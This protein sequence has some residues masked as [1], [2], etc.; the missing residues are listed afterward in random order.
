[1][2]Q[3]TIAVQYKTLPT[4]PGVYQYFDK[5]DT[6][7][8]VGKAKNLKRRVTSYFTKVHDN[9]KTRILVKKIHRMEHIVVPTEVDALLL[10]NNLIKKYRP[11]YNILLKD[12]KT[13]PWICIK[14]EAFP[15]VFSTR[16]VIRDGSD[17]FGPYPNVKTVYTLLELIRGLYPI[18]TCNFDLSEEKIKKQSYKVCLE[19]H[20]GNCLAPCESMVS[21]DDYN[22]NIAAIRE[23]IKGNFRCSLNQF[24]IQMEQ[25]ANAMEFERAQEIKEK[26][27]SLEN[28]Q[29]KSTV[30]NSKIT[31]V[32]VFTIISDESYGYVNFFQVAFG[33]IIRSHTVE[34]KKKLEETEAEMLPL[35][36]VNLRQRFNSQSKEILVPF[37]VDLGPK[38]KVTIPKLGDKKKLVELSQRN[39]KFFRLERFKQIKIVD[40]ERHIKRLMNQMK[41]DLRLQAEPIHIEC[42]DNSNIQGTNPTAACVVFRNGKPFKKD[43]R[44]FKIKTVEGP[45]D[46][47][48]MEEVVHRRYKRLSDEG[49]SLPQLIVIDG[50]KGQLSSAVKSLDRLGLRGQIAIIGIAKRLEEIYYPGDG[51]PMYLDKKSETLKVIQQLRNEAHRFGLTLHRNIRSKN[52]LKS[53]L[54]QVEG[55]GP[56]T[57]ELLL[58]EFK[59]L[60]RIKAT[61]KQDIID[62]LGKVKGVKIYQKLQGL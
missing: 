31:N 3:P 9:A 27:E 41:I 5:N 36:I 8:Y 38:I 61:S 37:E 6:V 35:A 57:K 2:E 29:A 51:I 20:I 17:Y 14:R 40:P 56:K 32:D 25:Y 24:K 59:S 10:E 60:K 11:R 21:E 4:D 48:S 13:Y 46:F 15:R 50:G 54:D 12:D 52:A 58:K 53:P 23:I 45:D 22:Q 62:I 55:I 19:Y 39:A 18:R 30:V 7:I 1:M 44:H 42:F 16:K 43:Y 47:A 49:Q 33:S 34:I 26:L 28:Y